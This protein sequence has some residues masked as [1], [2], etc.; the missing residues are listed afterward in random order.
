MANQ[1]ETNP[2]FRRAYER[3]TPIEQTTFRTKSP[4]LF[5]TTPTLTTTTAPTIYDQYKDTTP[6]DNNL[7]DIEN[8]YRRQSRQNI[9]EG[10]IYEQAAQRFQKEIDAT[11]QIYAQK[12]AQQKEIS[13]GNLGTSTAISARAGALGSP[14]GE[15]Q[16]KNIQ[17]EN[18][19]VEGSIL[20][21]QNAVIASILGKG[22]KEA[23]DEIAAKRA[24][25]EAGTKEY[26][27]FLKDKQ[28][29]TQ[30]K[31]SNLAKSLIAGGVKKESLDSKTIAD[32]AKSYGVST[33]DIL[34][35]YTDEQ[36]AQS[37][38]E[39]LSPAGLE[40][41]DA[42]ANGYTGS[43]NDYQT[44]DANRK[45]VIARAGV[46]NA[47]GL[48][49][50]Q[51][52]NAFNGIVGKYNASPLIQAADRTPVLAATISRIKTDPGNAAQQ[53]NLSYAYI[54]ALDT[55]QSAVREGELSNLNS[56]DSKIGSLGNYI[57]KIQNGQIVRPE[58]ALQIANA[59]EDLVNTIN[60]AAKNKA[61]S[62][63]AQA[64]VVGVGNQWKNYTSGF[65]T[66]YN[67][68]STG[69]GKSIDDYRAE[70]PQATD[71]ELQALMQEEG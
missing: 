20:A 41:R 30:S 10:D 13:R 39:K 16:Y 46:T 28:V 54:Q 44:L 58:V 26:L 38:D 5:G 57:Q 18:Q 53:L 60:T 12:L 19:S 52:V 7:N 71:E 62:F 45:A 6:Q 32:L 63:E 29:R 31:L 66:P 61:K 36:N 64:N 70:F 8:S 42:K 56:I 33:N 67:N 3:L 35:A 27:T 43:F 11:N 69:G 65:T 34:S 25:K 51:E 50:Y 15:A 55:Y 4:E 37:K 49:N 47:S 9:N 40:F 22:R 48:T 68:A 17:T 14:I 1:L 21:E 24:A 2:E 23:A 59:A